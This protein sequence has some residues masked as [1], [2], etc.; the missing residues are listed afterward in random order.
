MNDP[1]KFKE[2][3]SIKKSIETHWKEF[4]ELKIFSNEVKVPEINEARKEIEKQ[5]LKKTE[6]DELEKAKN[7]KI[8][9]IDSYEYDKN[10]NKKEKSEFE[11]Y[12]KNLNWMPSWIKKPIPSKYSIYNDCSD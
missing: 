7:K 4:E 8:Y 2:I 1:N 5:S 9:E 10:S 11:N 12:I 6:L 3:K